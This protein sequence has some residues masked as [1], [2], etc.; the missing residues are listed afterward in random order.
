MTGFLS[1]R[2][3]ELH[4]PRGNVLLYTTLFLLIFAACGSDTPTVAH[5]DKE[6]VVL[7]FGDSLTFGTGAGDDEDYPAR[8]EQMI[9]RRV[10]NAG[11]P[12]EVTSQGR[13][14][15]SEVLEEHQPTLLILCHGGNDMLRKMDE[16]EAAE[17]IRAMIRIARDRGIDV[18]LIGV[19]K[20]GLLLSN[21]DFYRQVAEEF[22]L[23]Y[24]GETLTEILSDGSLKSDPIHPNAE[25]YDRLARSVAT[26]LK[27]A[28]GL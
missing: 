9:A 11:V 3:G 4:K 27:E 16:R 26:L 6:A 14:R 28:K 10:I 24:D 2:L 7:A 8:L 21:A 23:P 13:A 1:G 15:L 25:G 12:G 18:I 17:N 22:S 20:P 5:L 19:P